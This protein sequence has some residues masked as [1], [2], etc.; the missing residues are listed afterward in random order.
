MKDNRFFVYLYRDPSRNNE[1][2]Y[3]GKGL[4]KRAKYHLKRTDMH[5][6]VQRLAFM[7]KNN[8]VPQ[9]EFLFENI[10][11]DEAKSLEIWFIHKF[12]R[13]DLGR[14]SLLNLTDGGDGSSGYKATLETRAKQSVG[15]KKIMT[16]EVRAKISKASQ[17][18]SPETRV[19]QSNASKNRSAQSRE[20]RLETMRLKNIN[21]SD[22]HMKKCTLDGIKI[23]SSV[24]EFIKEHGMGKTGRNS[25]DFRFI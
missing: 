5:P 24:R 13:K 8:I 23:Y 16:A 9:V 19:K 3:I 17:N 22:I 2:I 6:F 4:K 7:S 15:I 14:G 18:Y 12:G 21:H 11:D 1:P 20:K 25:P 10:T